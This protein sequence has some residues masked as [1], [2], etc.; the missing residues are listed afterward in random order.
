MPYC[1]TAVIENEAGMAI[2]LGS[3][4]T[5]TISEYTYLLRLT[6]FMAS[7]A[8][9]SKT[10]SFFSETITA[11]N[12]NPSS[13]YKVTNPSVSNNFTTGKEKP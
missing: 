10:T 1:I 8:T 13:A 5:S 7:F 9:G 2:T 12:I 6:Y 11:T 4:I 3:T